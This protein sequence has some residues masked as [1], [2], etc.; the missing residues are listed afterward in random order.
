MFDLRRRDGVG[1]LRMVGTNG[2]KFPGI[3]DHLKRA[4]GSAYRDM[5]IAFS[6]FPADDVARD[7]EAYRAAL[8]TIVAGDVVI[9]FTPDDTHFRIT[10]EAVQ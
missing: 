4:I 9:V 2:T 3:R 1:G 5:E 10:L 6:S 7:A 8:K